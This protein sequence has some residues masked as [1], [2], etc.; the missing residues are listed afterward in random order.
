[1]IAKRFSYGCAGILCLAFALVCTTRSVRADGGYAYVTQW[2]TNGTGNGQFDSPGGVAT[3]AAGNVYVADT[4]NSRIQKFTSDGAYLT[5][6][7]SPGPGPERFN[8]PPVGVAAGT[9]GNTYAVESG[10]PGVYAPRVLQ[11]T[12]TGAFVRFWYVGYRCAGV[13]TDES[14]NVYVDWT[15]NPAS[16]STGISKF[17][18]DGTSLGGWPPQQPAWAVAVAAGSGYVYVV[19]SWKSSIQ[20]FTSNGAYLTQWGTNG[21]GNGQFGSPHGVAIDG[22]GNVYVADTGNNRIQKFT[23]TGTYLA[24]WGTNGT[25]NGQFDSPHGVAIDGSGNVYVADTNNHRIQKFAFDVTPANASS[26]GSVK[27][28]FRAG[29]GAATQGK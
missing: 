10:A 11:F 15:G 17:T 4:G 14:G 6:W 8:T 16:E 28:R 5:R 25:G 2:G 18:S 22:S 23:G 13:A 1:L 27:A 12:N 3:D 26:W 9:S 29:T 24:Q 20:K 19:D 7:G 21:T